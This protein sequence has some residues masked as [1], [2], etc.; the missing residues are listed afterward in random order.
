MIELQ[1]NVEPPIDDISV[2]SFKKFQ[3]NMHQYHTV[4]FKFKYYFKI[5]IQFIGNFKWKSI[6]H[7][8][9]QLLTEIFCV[10]KIY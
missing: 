9:I 2:M 10:F 3:Y 6:S 4:S 5:Q 7:I 8:N 1:L